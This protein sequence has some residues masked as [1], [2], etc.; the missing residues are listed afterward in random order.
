MTKLYPWYISLRLA[1]SQGLTW[2][3]P[4]QK[5]HIQGELGFRDGWPQVHALQGPIA[6]NLHVA[7]VD[8]LCQQ[9]KRLFDYA[10]CYASRHQI[11]EHQTP[12]EQGTLPT[13]GVVIVL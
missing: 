7:C 13:V 3:S 5:L 12:D 4:T 1:R 6:A 2:F 9:Q 8:D 11:L 10:L